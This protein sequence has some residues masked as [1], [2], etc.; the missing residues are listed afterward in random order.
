M[1]NVAEVTGIA[2]GDTQTGTS[3]PAALLRARGEFLPVFV[4]DD[5]ADAIRRGLAGD[6]FDRPLTHDLLVEMVAEFGG[7]FDRVRIDDLRDGTFYAKIDAQRYEDG[8]PQSLTFDARPSDAVA[9]AIRADCPIEVADDVLDAAGR[10][11]EELG[12]DGAEEE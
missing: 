5:Q 11:G 6:S 7:A 2:T 9:V 10:S 12:V 4:T 3:V 8:E 1:S